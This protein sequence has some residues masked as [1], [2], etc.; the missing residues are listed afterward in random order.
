MRRLSAS[1][2]LCGFALLTA[3]AGPEGDIVQRNRSPSVLLTSYAI[4]NGM[5]EHGLIV[6]IIQKRATHEEIARLIAIDHNTWQL[7]KQA[8]FAPS[9]ENFRLADSG[10]NQI[11]EYAT[12]VTQPPSKEERQASDTR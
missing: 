10:I 12:P 6:R 4:A 2:L 3:C 1:A 5:A 7:I 9:E 8:A 11:L